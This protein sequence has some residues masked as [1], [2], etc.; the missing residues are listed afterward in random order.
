M[1]MNH[2]GNTTPPQHSGT[3]QISPIEIL[4]ALNRRKGILFLS[5]FIMLTVAALYNFLATPTYEATI[6]IKKEDTH[7]KQSTDQLRNIIAMQA[8]DGIETEMEVIKTGTV[9]EKVV[10]TLNL[11]F[12]IEKLE[13]P[14]GKAEKVSKYLCDYEDFRSETQHNRKA[15]PSFLE[16]NLAPDY[17][18]NKYYIESFAADVFKLYDSATGYLVQT[19]NSSSVPEFNLPIGT[20]KFKWPNAKKG[21]KIYF[22]IE[23]LDKTVLKLRESISIARIGETSIFKIT[24]AS[25]SPAAAQLIAN[26]IAEEFRTARL[27]QKRQTIRYS[28]NFIDEQLESISAKLKDAERDLHQFKSQH[29]IISI[30]ESS[31]E[32]I[33]FLSN[34]KTE[35]VKTDLELAEYQNKLEAMKKELE[36]KGFFDQTYLTPDNVRNNQTPFSALLEQL[37]NAELERLELLQRRT[38]S[39]PE[40][41]AINDRI[42][43]I[44]ERLSSYNQNTITAY[45]MRINT[46]KDKQHNLEK[47][48][49]KYSNIIKG[50]PSSE[51]K[52]AELMREKNVY[53]K[54]LTLLLDKRE[55]MRMAELSQLQDFVII[56]SAQKPFA[57]VSPHKKLNLLVGAFLGLLI[58]LVVVFAEELL[59][60]KIKGIEEIVEQYGIPLL[61]IV[62]K[63]DKNLQKVIQRGTTKEDYLVSLM[64]DQH[65]YRESYNLLRTKLIYSIPKSKKTIMITSCEENAGKTSVTANLAISLARMNKK[66]LVID[67]DLKKSEMGIYFDIIGR[68]SGFNISGL[69]E[70]LGKRIKPNIYQ[71]FQSSENHQLKVDLLPAGIFRENSS[72]LLASPKMKR[73]LTEM[74]RSYNYILIDT[75]PITRTVDTF[76]LGEFVKDIILVIRP[77][78]TFK[79]SVAWA[80]REFEQ[81]GINVLGVVANA[82]ELSKSDYKNRYDYGYGSEYGYGYGYSK[83]QATH[84]GFRPTFLQNKKNIL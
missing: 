74:K 25:A 46:L 4:R 58:G 56:D 14:N 68:N 55:E 66:V 1:A 12:M 36:E 19:V 52:L 67:C 77:E 30:N 23:D 31:T 83:K 38:E 5:V 2:I 72:E 34:L 57:P 18:A 73:L 43:Q 15:F 50:L 27:E 84:S 33:Q 16:V 65:G 39:H 20:I 82:C 47:L 61:T 13:L 8:T 49:N 41:I 7:D 71:P 6:T 62:P 54:I 26:T 42:A 79:D 69:G 9:L 17:N 44:R 28:Y 64:E 22:E 70:F 78:H 81:A 60:R 11:N 45:Q 80:F 32:A 59:G 75:P 48:M 21:S 3:D 10:N 40:V 29:Q 24:V 53:D 51:T 37:S 35:K 76:I 63:Y